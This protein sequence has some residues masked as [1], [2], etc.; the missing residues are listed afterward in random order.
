MDS[1]IEKLMASLRKLISV[2]EETRR[3]LDAPGNDFTWSSWD[4]REDALNEI[5][6]ILSVLRS[7]SLP[8]S[9]TLE[10]LFAPTGPIQEVS[11]SSGW[12]SEFIKL[13][14]RFDDAMASDE[15]RAVENQHAG[16]HET[17]GC[18]AAPLGHVISIKE[19]GMDRRFAEVSLLVCR[20]C[21]Q[22][23][24]RYFYEVEA[25]T[26]SGRW[27]LG[28]VTPEQLS[29]LTLENA[30]ETLEKLDCYYYG[31]SYYEGRSGRTSGKIFLSP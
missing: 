26:G 23:W 2:L 6:E 22:H 13:S 20:D 8:T 12:G 28:A 11:L 29:T 4:G 9:L 27:Y 21:G 10:T 14:E 25:F 31:G 24:L 7:G 5:D 30:K 15:E 1:E 17:C 18:F 19:L 16:S 3:L